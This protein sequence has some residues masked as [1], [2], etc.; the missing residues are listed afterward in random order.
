M[1]ARLRKQGRPLDAAGKQRSSDLMEVSRKAVAKGFASFVT[2]EELDA[3][4]GP[5][6]Y[7]LT[8]RF[9]VKQNG[10]IGA[11]LLSDRTL[12]QRLRQPRPGV[13][14][15]FGEGQSTLDATRLG[16]PFSTDAEKCK[17]MAKHVVFVGIFTD[18]TDSTS[19]EICL[20]VKPGRV[21]QIESVVR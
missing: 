4:F 17:P 3:E 12:L 16:F 11:V 18:L 7:R 5:G 8:K 13:R 14:G 15:H 19:G 9:G 6:G 21:E 10:S 1:T 20:R 2:T